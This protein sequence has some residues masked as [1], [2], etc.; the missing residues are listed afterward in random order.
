MSESAKPEGLTKRQFLRRVIV[1]GGTVTFVAGGYLK[2]ELET[3]LGPDVAHAF[4]SGRASASL[5]GPGRGWGPGG[6]P[7]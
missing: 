3:L 1:G 2:P 7:R 5:Q 6:R 4:A